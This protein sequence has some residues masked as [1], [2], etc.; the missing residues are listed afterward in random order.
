M[1]LL[2]GKGV[3][4]A[5]L[6]TPGIPFAKITMIRITVENRKGAEGAALRSGWGPEKFPFLHSLIGVF[7]FKALHV[8]ALPAKNGNV[9][10]GAQ[11]V[12]FNVDGRFLRVDDACVKE[13]ANHFTQAT[14]TALLLVNLDFHGSTQ[15]SSG[16][17][18]LGSRSC[19][20]REACSIRP[21][22]RQSLCA[23]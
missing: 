10:A 6:E 23:R 15:V 8:L 17:P 1:G 12:A 7:P 18:S 5:Y 2:Q 4:C 19:P 9:E 3:G 14:P 22:C 21:A 16:F 20:S 13:R 11:V